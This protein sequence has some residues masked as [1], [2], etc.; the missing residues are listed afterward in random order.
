MTTTKRIV[1]AGFI[2]IL[3]LGIAPAQSAS[4]ATKAQT[5]SAPCCR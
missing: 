2:S 3:A 1:I 5:I 4:A